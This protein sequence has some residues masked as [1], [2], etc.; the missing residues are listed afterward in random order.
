MLRTLILSAAIA[1]LVGSASAQQKLQ[2][3]TQKATANPIFAGVFHPA[4]GLTSAPG[5]TVRSGPVML[6]NNN[7]YSN[8]Y[9]LPGKIQEWVDNGKLLDRNHDSLE[10]I[11]SF[12]FTYCSS[13]PNAN[14]VATTVRFYDDSIYCGGPV[15]WP[16]SE[17]AYQISDLPGGANGNLAC[18]IVLVDLSGLECN[19]TS[20]PAGNRR[21]GWGHSWNND[22]SGPWIAK[23]GY[24]QT[25]SFT[26]WDRNASNANSAYQGCFWFGSLPWVGFA[27]AAQGNYAETSNVDC[28]P[29]ANDSLWLSL[30]DEVQVGNVMDWTVTGQNPG[31]ATHFWT[32]PNVVCNDLNAFLGIDA[33]EVAQY[34]TRVMQNDSFGIHSF[35]IPTAAGGGLTWYTQAATGSTGLPTA[36]SN[37]LKHYVF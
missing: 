18:W 12:D 26:W 31:A 20:D 4:T 32:S 22:F 1:T 30:N 5:N 25:D 34:S 16:T 11:S 15:N 21:F 6:Y 24:G 14:G 7:D 28:T 19:L 37:G 3:T 2:W 13:D 27:L 17:C 35:T 29:G 36:M 10:Q 23:G 33:H 9:S 8:Y